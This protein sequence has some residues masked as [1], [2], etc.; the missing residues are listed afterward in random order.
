MKTLS[1]IP[2]KLTKE[3]IESTILEYYELLE[4]MPLNI[5]SENILELLT[6][7][8]RKKTDTGPYPNVTL[9]ESA[10]RIMTDLTILIGIKRLF[11]DAIPEINYETYNVEFGHDN[12]NDFDI[13]AED[14]NQKLVGE[15]FNVAKQFFQPKKTKMLKKLR[16]QGDTNDQKLLIYNSDAVSENYRPKHVSNEFHL[17]VD[18]EF[19]K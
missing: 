5:E 9:F 12:F 7:L 10:N 13:I 2:R 4:G 1:D 14:N 18:I 3:N 15:V 6:E 17:K 16:E 19:W 11:N 8:K